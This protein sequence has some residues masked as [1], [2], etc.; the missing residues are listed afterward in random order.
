MSDDELREWRRRL[1]VD[2]RFD[3]GVRETLDD[4]ERE[5]AHRR[6]QGGGGRPCLTG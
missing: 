3:P 2:L 5:V 1:L 6:R 4:V